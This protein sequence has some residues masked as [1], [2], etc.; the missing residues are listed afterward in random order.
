M[1]SRLML[2]RRVFLKGITGSA[3]G[4]M[5]GCW[6]NLSAA[7]TVDTIN[8]GILSEGFLN[9]PD[10]ARPWV[11]W[12]WING[13]ITREGITADLEAMQR[14]G[15]GGV[16]IMEV[17]GSPQ[18]PVA[19]GTSAWQE[20]F[21]FACQEAARLGLEINM[22]DGAGWT[23]SGGPWNTA[24]NSMQQ[25]LYSEVEVEGGKHYNEELP[26]PKL[27]K[28]GIPGTEAGEP[29]YYCDIAVIA[30]PT[31]KNDSFRTDNIQLKAGF[32]TISTP[33]ARLR[34]GNNAFQMLPVSGHPAPDDAIIDHNEILNLTAEFKDGRLTWDVP[35]GKW[36]ILRFGHGPT[37][38]TN[39]PAP[40]AGMGYEC[41]K[42]SK[43]A[44]EIH[45]NKFLGDILSLAGPLTG[46][47]LVATHVDSWEVDYQNWTSG[48]PEE[49]RIRCGYDIFPFLPAMTGRII[50]NAEVTERFLWDFRFTISELIAENYAGHMRE[51]SN[52]HGIQF[53]MEA[54]DNTPFDEIRVAGQSNLPQTEFWYRRESEAVGE[55]GDCFEGVFR[56]YAWTPAMVSAAHIYGSKIIP[57][58]AFTA[59]PGENWL[60]HPALLKPQGDWAFCAGINRFIFHR[61]AMQPWLDRKPGMTMA[62]WGLHYER[63]QTWWE[64]TKPWHQYLTR[65]QYLLQK[66]L[67][68]A[69]LLYMQAES[70]PNRFI[71][72]NTDFSNPIPPDPPEYNFDGCTADVV[73][74][75]ISIKDGL[76]L[77][78]DGMSYR[79]MVLP[80]P[81][82]QLMAGVMT[83]KLIRKIEKLVN[84]GMVIIGPPPLKTPGLTNY[85][86]SE[87]ELKLV[88]GRLWGDTRST[89][90]RRV[91]KGHVY[92][93]NTPQ[94]VLASLGIP[95]DF[96][97]G[98]P[99]PF[100]YIHR[101]AEDGSEIYFVSNKQNAEVEAICNFRVSNRRP[102]FWWPETGRT[103]KPAI[104]SES[105]H[106]TSL[107]VRLSEFGSVF[108]VFPPESRKEPD[109]IVKIARNGKMLT[110]NI[111]SKI[112]VRHYE[113][114]FESLIALAGQY[115]LQTSD[116]KEFRI[117]IAKLPEP[118]KINGPWDVQ[119]APDWGAPPHV[120]FPE[121]ASWSD[122]AD[123]GVRYFSGKATYHKKITIP[124]EM[125][126]S[127]RMLFLDLGEVEVMAIV[128]LNGKELGILWKKPFRID[129]TSAVQVG[130]NSVEVT[131][132]NLWPN[133]L[134]GDE[135]LPEDR[136]WSEKGVATAASKTVMQTLKEYPRWFL[137][138]KPSPT[139]RFT[140]SIIKVWSKDDALRKS[141]LLGPVALHVFA[142]VIS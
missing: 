63:T 119:F 89:G 120:Q 76:I 142:K 52:R 66:G 95:K 5:A 56:S 102:E 79:A 126:K 88:V 118:V 54:I 12:F 34:G 36:T 124:A 97:C 75:R 48:F 78:P 23:G 17:D 35:P 83:L 10:D 104:F 82:E 69:D 110:N 128:K 98:K 19:F 61:Y 111:G 114:R 27:R 8:S 49:F 70:A 65:C 9:P 84:E 87:D 11:Y 122:H 141:G 38:A 113:G 33:P 14:V 4:I 37:G 7:N 18:G 135:F 92:W 1:S 6:I 51:L 13:N 15:I 100:R 101:R 32:R 116:S 57:S 42:L 16:L 26:R 81:G 134:I 60:A 31:P 41:D 96:S 106:V 74:K 50:G 43:E 90:D 40:S 62:F 109:R 2:N 58:E 64:E 22:N 99:A 86:Q 103:E 28:G 123:A 132:V 45:F 30:F 55:S 94:E 59:N 117:D 105:D 107:P 127:D 93:G 24:E 125:V 108:V 29:V 21:R 131:V 44:V 20:M 140:F 67:F 139:G 47:T 85:P 68:V 46:K 136:N 137:D 39:H 130:E 121:L 112:K 73:F 53:S 25:V 3:A 115:T 71:P 77:L 72:P 91:G 138:G 133:R 129:I 80:S